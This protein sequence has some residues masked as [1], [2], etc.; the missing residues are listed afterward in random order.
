MTDHTDGAGAGPDSGTGAGRSRE[1]DNDTGA[2][3][4]AVDLP[5]AQDGPAEGGMS[6]PGAGLGATG[7]TADTFSAGDDVRT[8]YGDPGGAGTAAEEETA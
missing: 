7:R 6:G 5:P 3:T 1:T 2:D 8:D 4:G